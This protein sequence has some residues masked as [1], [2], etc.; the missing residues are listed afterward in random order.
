MKSNFTVIYDACVLYPAPLRDLLMRLA[1]TDLYRARWTDMI[2]DEWT[3][4]VLK[5]R[6]DLTT[7]DL[8]RTRCLMNMHVR[9]CLVTGFEHLIPSV[10]LPD[11]DD[12][13]VLAAAIH[14]GANLIVTFNLKD[15]PQDQLKR[16]RLTAQHPD[17][18]IFDLL[19]LH[20]ARVCE[21]VASH[22]RSLKNPPKTADEYLD[23]LLK[24]GL[25][26][27]VGLLREWKVAI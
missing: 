2:H 3:R 24:Q 8:A 11:A 4:N 12:R 20:A 14:A 10:E 16:Y 5:Q 13:H 25:T 27:T 23:T 22:R 1:L 7:E 19:D 18:F 15:F 17:D 26:H 21:A 6:P 9:D